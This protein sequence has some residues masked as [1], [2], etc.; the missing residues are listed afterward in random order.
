MPSAGFQ[1]IRPDATQA[2]RGLHVLVAGPESAPHAPVSREAQ[3]RINGFL[4]Y[5]QS[6]H[7]DITRQVLAIDA[8]T[9]DGA[10]AG[11]CLW[12]PSPG[13]T[14][15]LFAPAL[16][17]HPRAAAATEAAISAA[18]EDARAAGVVL[19][20]AMMEP[21]DAAGKTVFAAAGLAQLAT[22]TYMERRPPMQPPEFT[23]PADY[24]LA[25]YEAS[26]HKLF[27]EAILKSYY[28]TLDCP[29]MSG[30]RDIEDVI[31]G[32]KAVG[33]LGSNEGTQEATSQ[34]ANGRGGFDPQLWGVLLRWNKP[35]GCLLLAEVAARGALELV[36]L[37]LAPEVR[38]QG[39]G[40]ALM[41]RMLAI[42]S[43]RHF[44]TATLAVDAANTPAAKLYRRCG[45]TSVAQRVAM[46]KRL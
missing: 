9:G 3:E 43:R 6:I 4:A 30:L 11:M 38:G 1:L 32:H 29:A 41:Q 16:S 7:L 2:M 10:V 25:P 31:E 21:A 14:A 18:L 40:R 33:G 26:T 19:V 44:E 46:I 37:G 13:R 12:V 5:A 8:A 45:F 20:Q 39:L 28:D 23:L 15:M 34:G 27:C 22:L 36:Y 42:A 17:D 24:S 35:V